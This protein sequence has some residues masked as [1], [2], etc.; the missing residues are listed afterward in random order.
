MK[1][2]KRKPLH[3]IYLAGFLIQALMGLLLRLLPSHK[4]TDA[5]TKQTE[6]RVILY[7]HKL[8]GNLLALYKQL[9]AENTSK[10]SPVFLTMDYAYH[11]E[12]QR[13]G[14][15]SQWALGTGCARLLANASCI[16]SDH[17][18]HSLALVQSAIRASGL[19]FFDV[20]HGI[21][22][23]GF[24]AAD[25]RIQHRYNEVWVAS[26]LHKKLYVERFG[27]KS[28][29]ALAEVVVTGYGRTDQLVSARQERTEAREKLSLPA[30]GPIILFAPTW[31]QDDRGRS[32]YPFGVGEEEFL[33][34]LSS[35]A[36]KHDATVVM[37]THLN[38]SD[39]QQR[40]YENV[41]FMPGTVYPEAE[42]ILLASDLLV[43][44]WSSIAFDYL[45]LDRPTLFLE[46]PPPFEKGF[47][48]GP[49][50]RFGEIVHDF[51]R[52][53]DEI[54]SIL[55]SE[56][57]YWRDHADQHKQAKI[58]IYG[59]YADG[60]SSQRYV[61][62]IASTAEKKSTIDESSQS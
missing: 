14:I 55:V 44:D 7:G 11:Q 21:P 24:D 19:C 18:L 27:F 49:E 22:F 43:C 54:D 9:L 17:G 13:K 46:V 30:S 25:F 52:L 36:R 28:K 10:L 31:A 5:L 33:G 57:K 51:Q 40:S 45:L 16:V 2:N 6:H 53:L 8:N 37:R 62:R 42:P 39:V 59:G 47:S 4:K 41:T 48:L 32:I 20:W 29:E 23:K 1:I 50:Y 15:H 60:R 35:L 56:E 12:L 34:S 58:D 3:W 38:S 26:P 61:Q